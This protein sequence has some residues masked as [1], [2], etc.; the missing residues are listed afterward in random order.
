MHQTSDIINST[1]MGRLLVNKPSSKCVY[2][3]CVCTRD[4]VTACHRHN[5]SLRQRRRDQTRP[6]VFAHHI[7]THT[8]AHTTTAAHVHRAWRTKPPGAHS[9]T[10][11]GEQERLQITSLSHAKDMGNVLVSL[12]THIMWYFIIMIS[13]SSSSRLTIAPIAPSSRHHHPIMIG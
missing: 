3:V 13:F 8:R 6:T 7:K 2:H 12:V 10:R 9:W 4:R 11:H 1:W 5:D